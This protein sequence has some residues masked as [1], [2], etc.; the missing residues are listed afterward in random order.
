VALRPI[1]PLSPG[2]RRRLAL[3]REVSRLLSPITLPL[4][5]VVLRFGL[6]YRIED[7]KA[8]RREYRDICLE[9]D[10]SMLICANHLTMIDSFVI[11]WALGS[12][13]WYFGH[14][15]TLPWNVPERSIFATTPVMRMLAYGLKCLPIERGGNRA[16]I[17]GVLARVTHALSRRNVTL[18]FPEGGRSR[19]GRVEVDSAASGV[20][21]ICRSVPGCRVICVYLRGDHQQGYSGIPVR[22]E[23][24]RGSLS[25]IEPKT[26]HQGL[27]AS[28][29]VARQIA[30]RLAEMEQ[31]YF[32]DRK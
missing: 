18:I 29:D 6:G 9:W 14:F 5:A 4:V 10:G 24:F 20:G 7:L 1:A 19:T 28:R 23:H 27:R 21:R 25:I 17:N 16:E 32:D 12:P 8:L 26:D 3:Q 15:R 2:T 11:A 13:W 31:E 22:G 30:A